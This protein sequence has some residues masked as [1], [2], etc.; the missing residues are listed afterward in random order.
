MNKIELFDNDVVMKFNSKEVCT[1][2]PKN[3]RARVML[4]KTKDCSKQLREVDEL[5][6]DVNIDEVEFINKFKDLYTEFISLP[7]SEGEPMYSIHSALTRV[8]SKGTKLYRVVGN[9][10]YRGIN[11]N[12]H[13]GRM[14]KENEPVLYTAFN[15]KVALKEVPESQKKYLN[16]YEVINDIPVLYC[17]FDNIA[18]MECVTDDDRKIA[19][20][21]LY[22]KNSILTKKAN[23]RIKNRLYLITNW[24]SEENTI[25][26]DCSYL[27]IVYAS[28]KMKVNQSVLN[29]T[30]GSIGFNRNAD[31]VFKGTSLDGFIQIKQQRKL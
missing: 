3:Q 19:K 30:K 31:F 7:N 12:S 5:L 11:Y 15:K 20:Q 2:I 21:I 18:C 10:E 6:R 1:D 14:N 16:E 22:F 29:L 25:N 8:I 17:Q 13:L 9:K 26:N 27:G 23:E 4:E 24:L 28:T